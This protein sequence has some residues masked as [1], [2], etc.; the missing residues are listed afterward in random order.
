M[1]IP[2]IMLAIFGTVAI[3]ERDTVEQQKQLRAAKVELQESRRSSSLLSAVLDTVDVGVL[4]LDR[5]GEIILMN[6]RQ[7]LNHEHAAGGDHQLCGG[8][9]GDFRSGPEDA[10]ATARPS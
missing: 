5:H 9:T 3:V 4:A 10:A 6:N 2:F 1:L 7:V 8:D